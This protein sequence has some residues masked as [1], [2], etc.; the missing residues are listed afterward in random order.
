MHWIIICLHHKTVIK[1][2]IAESLHIFTSDSVLDQ[3]TFKPVVSANKEVMA[4]FK[5]SKHEDSFGGCHHLPSLGIIQ[6]VAMHS[7]YNNVPYVQCTPQ[8]KFCKQPPTLKTGEYVSSLMTFHY[9]YN[10]L[11]I[12]LKTCPSVCMSIHLSVTQITHL[13]L[14]RLTYQLPNTI[15]QSSHYS[16]LSPWSI[17]VI[18]L[19]SAAGWRQRS[20]AIFHQK[21][22]PYSSMGRAADLHSGGSGFKS[23]WWTLVFSK[24]NTFTCT[25]SFK[26]I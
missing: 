17:T 18:S 23:S 24:I 15:N 4:V 11:Y 20:G 2:I 13:G 26:S 1:T 10:L 12:K 14:L 22:Q 16:S 21:A 8:E 7:Y 6:G 9:R 19:R 25:F 3:A 5:N